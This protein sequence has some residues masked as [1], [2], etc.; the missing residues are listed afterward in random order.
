MA[1]PTTSA[2]GASGGG[3]I[4]RRFVGGDRP[5]R[6]DAQP[7]IVERRSIGPG[8]DADA[9]A[10][11][12]LAERLDTVLGHRRTPGR[13]AR[14][15]RAHPDDRRRDEARVAGRRLDHPD[16]PRRPPRGHRLGR[17]R[18]RRRGPPA[19]P[20]SRRGLGRRGPAHGSRPGLRRT[21]GPSASTATPGTTASPSIAGH[22]VAPLVHN[23]RVI[24]ALSA[25]T[26]GSASLDE[27]RRGLHL[28]P[29]DPRRD[30]PGQRRA[31]RADHRPGG[32]ARGP[33]DRVR[34]DEPGRHGRGGRPDR[35]RG[36]RTGSSITTTPGSTWSSSRTT[37]SRSPSRAASAPTSTS[38]WHCSS[39]G[40]GRA[41]P[42]GSPSTASRS[43]STTR[44]TTR[45]ARRS[46]GPRT[47]TSRCWSCRCATTARRSASSRCRS[48]VWTASARTTCAS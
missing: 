8:R 11:A 37:S 38:T 20:P 41:S 33:P 28:D 14:P 4:F 15:R 48:S 9:R 13:L 47:S 2:T 19:G 40:S 5:T 25:L 3:S 27:R 46:P 44:T 42:A 7:E 30:R 22:L 36:D 34:A 45:A 16:A 6:T 43:S 29:G 1:V 32:P 12:E 10:E 18:R 23:G 24:G 35:R 21:S 26:R 31:V 39:A 17:S